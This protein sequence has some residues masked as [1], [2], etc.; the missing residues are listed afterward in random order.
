MCSHQ[1]SFYMFSCSFFLN[2]FPICHP[3]SCSVWRCVS[4]VCCVGWGKSRQT[5]QRARGRFS[6][7]AQLT[8]ASEDL[9]W[10]AWLL[11]CS[12]RDLSSQQSSR[13]D[14]AEVEGRKR[15]EKVNS[16]DNHVL[17]CTP[18]PLPPLPWDA[19]WVLA[20]C[21]LPL[22]A[23][24]GHTVLHGSAMLNSCFNLS[25]VHVCVVWHFSLMP[26]KTWPQDVC[27]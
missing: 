16:W 4:G 27:F 13:S 10:D 19:W 25:V 21:A 2:S 3:S 7:A 22:L 11:N 12:P 24:H 17:Y 14:P 20:L 15:E 9:R 6:N 23:V 8:W 1:T 18:P 26:P 5:P